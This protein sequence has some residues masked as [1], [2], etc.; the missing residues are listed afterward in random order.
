MPFVRHI[1][2]RARHRRRTGGARPQATASLSLWT[3]SHYRLRVK[4]RRC[5][6]PIPTRRLSC[7]AIISSLCFDRPPRSGVSPRECRSQRARR[8]RAHAANP[9]APSRLLV[10]DTSRTTVTQRTN[11]KVFKT[12]HGNKRVNPLRFWIGVEIQHLNPKNVNLT[13]YYLATPTSKIHIFC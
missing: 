9:P 6:K 2:W 4:S 8:A 1:F 12:G 10:S 5:E 3:P 11:Y 13:L 7:S